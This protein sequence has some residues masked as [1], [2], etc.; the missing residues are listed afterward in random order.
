MSAITKNIAAGSAVV[1]GAIIANRQL[2]SKS[3]DKIAK[4]GDSYPP[5]GLSPGVQKLPEWIQL[6]CGST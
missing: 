2:G 6:G 5:S 4:P 3:V 1:V